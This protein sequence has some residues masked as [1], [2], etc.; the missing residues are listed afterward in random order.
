MSY[1]IKNYSEDYL[2]QQFELGNSVLN[3]WPGAGQ[4]SVENLKQAYS[5]EN[6]DPELKIYAF[7][8]EELV[9]FCTANPIANQAEG[10]EKKAFL[11]FPIVKEGYEDAAE[12]LFSTALNT[13]RSK[14]FKAVRTRAG[15]DWTGTPELV[16]KHGYKFHSELFKRATF[17]P[18]EIDLNNLTESGSIEQLNFD[19][20]TKQLTELI[21]N[22]YS[23]TDEQ[24][25]G[26]VDN[27]IN[28]K[29][30]TVS[31]DIILDNDA[32]VARMLIYYPDTETKD[33][34]DFTRPITV[35]DKSP[36]YRDRLMRSAISK[37]QTMPEVT[38]ARVYL[39]GNVMDNDETYGS[40]S[41]KFE[42][43]LSFYEKEI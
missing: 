27:L 40:L 37:L 25:K 21:K 8:D 3:K 42:A 5:A 20:H 30:Q 19:T 4:T 43:P 34:V 13:L 2:E 36:E 18:K 41:L 9:G 22:E 11:E 32:I 33:T 16:D 23:I 10:E 38:T 26:A 12:Q 7:K 15:K 35:G 28:L 31:H 6:F 29:S 1:T 17:N 14:G 39:A 24:A